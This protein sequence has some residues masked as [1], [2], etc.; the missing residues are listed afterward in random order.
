[1]R[2]W[3]VGTL[4]APNWEDPVPGEPG[5]SIV[6]TR[7][8]MTLQQQIERALAAGILYEEWRKAHFPPDSSVP[9]DF[10]PEGYE[11]DEMDIMQEY[12]LLVDGRT[13]AMARIEQAERKAKEEAE[14]AAK[15]ASEKGKKPVEKPDEVP[16]A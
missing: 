15:L 8:Y 14:E 4:F 6:E 5:D 13:R 3:P 7:G 11:P 9:D 1:M 12:Q 16:V 2:I 10:E